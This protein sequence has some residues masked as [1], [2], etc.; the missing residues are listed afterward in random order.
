MAAARPLSTVPEAR[1]WPVLGMAPTFLRDP[2]AYVAAVRKHGP[3]V[4]VRFAGTTLLYL[5]EPALLG[6]LFGRGH[7]RFTKGAFAGR[8]ARVFGEGLLLAEGE[9]WRRQRVRMAPAFRSTVVQSFSAAMEGITTACLDR[10]RGPVIQAATEM[11]GLTLEIAVRTL[12]GT[13]TPPAEKQQVARAFTIISN[14]FASVEGV[15]LQLP[16]WVPTPANRRV[17]RALAELDAVVQRIIDERRRAPEPGADLLGRLLQG[18][19]DDGKTMSDAQL[20]DEVRTLLLAGHETTAIGLATALWALS[21]EW[22]L[23]ERL[24]QQITEVTGDQPLRRE[25]LSALPLLEATWKEALRLYPPAPA[26]FRE[27]TEDVELGGILVPKG[28]TIVVPV[29]QVH[30]EP[31]LYEA[32]AR[33][34]PERW[35]DGTERP[36]HAYLPFGAGP[37]IC[38]GMGLAMLEGPLVLGEVLRRFRLTRPPGARLSLVPAVTLRAQEPIRIGITPRHAPA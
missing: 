2:F 29:W 3:V 8:G 37:R 9:H 26:F 14:H 15:V 5:F 16:P 6:E 11:M 31:S 36:R 1:G 25:H 7:R 32:P 21:G 35:L 22:E 24:A 12:F 23:Q 27:P 28:T 18:R 20:Q 38:I 33:F 4:R 17:D 10:W 30:R 13:A 34:W 19:D